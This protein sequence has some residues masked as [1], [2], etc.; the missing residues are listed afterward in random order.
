MHFWPPPPFSIISAYP[1]RGSPVLGRAPKGGNGKS[2]HLGS[3][4]NRRRRMHSGRRVCRVSRPGRWPPLDGTLGRSRSCVG[5]GRRACLPALASGIC[6]SR[7]FP[8]WS[9]RRGRE[10]RGASAGAPWPREQAWM[11]APRPLPRGSAVGQGC[12]NRCLWRQ[13]RLPLWARRDAGPGLACSQP[14]LE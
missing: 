8:L 10:A 7:L 1:S 6:G 3:P 14:K 11:L 13:P 4:A 2:E 12:P 5:N 9:A